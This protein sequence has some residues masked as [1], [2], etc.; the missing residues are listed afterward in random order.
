M[1]KRAIVINI[2]SIVDKLIIING[3]NTGELLENVEKTL[4]GVIRS[5]AEKAIA[6]DQETE[7]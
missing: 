4:L 6:S 1:E 5:A 2:N 3:D 7:D